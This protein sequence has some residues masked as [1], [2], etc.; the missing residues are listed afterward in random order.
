MPLF[1]LIMMFVQVSIIILIYFY[2]LG[3]SNR[4]RRT[5][6]LEEQRQILELYFRQS[7]Y[8]TTDRIKRIAP[9]IFLSEDVMRTW[10][11]NRRAKEQR[12]RKRQANNILGDQNQS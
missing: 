3:K 11:K 5:R 6:F 9:M 10:F 7:P 1:L 4:L 2:A 8:M 12:L